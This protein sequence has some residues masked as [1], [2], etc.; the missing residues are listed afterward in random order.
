MKKII[1]KLEVNFV[2]VQ[3]GDL[4]LTELNIDP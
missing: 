4:L 3:K 1:V 2:D